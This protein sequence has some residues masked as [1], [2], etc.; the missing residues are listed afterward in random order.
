MALFGPDGSNG[1]KGDWT[2]DV[3]ASGQ[4]RPEANGAYSRHGLAFTAMRAMTLGTPLAW[5]RRD[6]PISEPKAA[7]LH[8]A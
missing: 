5:H 6:W 1:Y 7:R 3:G 4:L 8:L 2:G